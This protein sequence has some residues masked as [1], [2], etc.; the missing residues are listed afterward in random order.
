MKIRRNILWLIMAVLSLTSCM[1]DDPGMDPNDMESD[2]PVNKNV[3]GVCIRF[4]TEAGLNP[5]KVFSDIIQPREYDFFV[6]DSLRWLDLECLRG[7]DGARMTFGTTAWFTP[8]SADSQAAIGGE[9]PVLLVSWT[10]MDLITGQNTRPQYDETY[11]LNIRSTR[12]FGNDEV[13]QIKWY[14]HVT[15]GSWTTTRIVA[16]GKEVNQVPDAPSIGELVK[17]KVQY[18]P[19]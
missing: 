7:S 15:N 16:D 10:D 14:V 19:Q 12:L 18:Q 13:R 1:V 3:F 11:T 6:P 8:Q 4:E 5:L 2:W 9:G 17:L